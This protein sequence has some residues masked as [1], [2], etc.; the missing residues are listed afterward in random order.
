MSYIKK[1]WLGLKNEWKKIHTVVG[2][3]LFIIIYFG[4]IDGDF[5]DYWWL[6]FF[7][8]LYVIIVKNRRLLYNTLFKYWKKFWSSLN[9]GWKRI[10]YLFPLLILLISFLLSIVMSLIGGNGFYRVSDYF[11]G[12]FILGVIILPPLYIITVQIVMWIKDGFNQ[13]DEKSNKSEIINH[14][15]KEEKTKSKKVNVNKKNS[16]KKKHKKN[17]TV[18]D[19]IKEMEEKLP[20]MS[21]EEGNKWL[22]K[23]KEKLFKSTVKEITNVEYEDL[24]DLDKK[25]LNDITNELD[26]KNVSSSTENK[27]SS[28]HK[29]S[30]DD[31]K[32]GLKKFNENFKSKIKN[33]I[34]S[35]YFSNGKLKRESVIENGMKNGKERTFYNNGKVKEECNYLNGFLNGEYTSFHENGKKHQVYIYKNGQPIET[36]HWDEN[37]NE[38]EL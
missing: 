18:D 29:I 37:G 28:E 32:E 23:Q 22:E 13:N 21:V 27:T 1:Y 3:L 30:E 14:E 26:E 31:F 33:G 25:N 9:T 15:I 34:D 17:K 20:N 12:F 11:G 8:P 24:S 5:E 6:Y 35:E 16:K 38:I 36:E 2:I 4:F 7:L 19:V 10:H